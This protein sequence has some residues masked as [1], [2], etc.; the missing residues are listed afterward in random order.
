MGGSSGSSYDFNAPGSASNQ[1]SNI[2]RQQYANYQ[3]VYVPEENKLIN[4]ATDPNT[5]PNAQKQAM[6]LTAGAFKSQQQGQQ[7]S[8]NGSGITLTP[9]M[10]S[11]LQRKN[12]IQQTV[13]VDD[14]ANRAGISA[15]DNV[16]A[17]LSGAP[18]P[19]GILPPGSMSTQPPTSP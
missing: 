6:G 13:A 17:A 8:F 10:Q 11:A 14:S 18:G 5:I 15:Y 4:W 1:L 19:T 2:L 12:Q 3:A 7:K 16:S 9:Q